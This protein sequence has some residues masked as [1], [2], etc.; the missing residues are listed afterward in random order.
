MLI[1][2]RDGG[3]RLAAIYQIDADGS[4]DMLTGPGSEKGLHHVVGGKL[5]NNPKDPILIADDLVS[6]IE[7]NRLTGKPVVR[8]VKLENLK[9]V[10]ETVRRFN[11]EHG[12][13]IAATDAHIAKENRPIALAKEAAE[14]VKGKLLMPPLSE[15]DKEG[16]LM[17]F[18]QLLKSGNTTSVR[19]TFTLLVSIQ[20]KKVY[21]SHI[22]MDLND[23]S[24]DSHSNPPVSFD[25][26]SLFSG[27]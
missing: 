7:L 25:Q 1:P 5:S 26:V 19:K 14:A 22:R 10:A 2:L 3:N 21:P 17:S 20:P 6:A 16:V 8:A 15:D 27:K 12:I 4:G 11:P 23:T 13:V 9:A 24:E 18:G